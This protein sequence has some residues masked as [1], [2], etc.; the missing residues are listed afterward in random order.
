[1]TK[2][3]EIQMDKKLRSANLSTEN[4][5]Q[6]VFDNES[7]SDSSFTVQKDSRGDSQRSQRRDEDQSLLVENQSEFSE[8]CRLKDLVK[9]HS[10]LDT[11]RGAALHVE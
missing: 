10:E 11:R 4:E 9:K 1:M 8:T 2:H 6:N 5:K 3:S 7:P